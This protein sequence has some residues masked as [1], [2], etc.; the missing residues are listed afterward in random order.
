LTGDLLDSLANGQGSP[1]LSDDCLD[2]DD[3]ELM[4][5]DEMTLDNEDGVS[6]TDSSNGYSFSDALSPTNQLTSQLSS[7][8]SNQ[9][10]NQLTN[11]K[12]N[13]QQIASILNASNTTT[14]LMNS[15]L[16]SML[17]SVLNSNKADEKTCVENLPSPSPES[18]NGS[19]NDDETTNE[20]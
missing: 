8:L 5:N 10:T 12:D 3:E 17:N 6:L 13:Q 2:E 14:N 9:L 4:Y 16:N 7:Q 20:K 18:A 19:L 15:Q 11:Q 1:N